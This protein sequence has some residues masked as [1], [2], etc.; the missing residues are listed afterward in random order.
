LRFLNTNICMPIAESFVP[1]PQSSSSTSFTDDDAD[2]WHAAAASPPFAIGAAVRAQFLRAC[3]RMRA[4]W[5][6]MQR[7]RWAAD[8]SLSASASASA[9]GTAS[10]NGSGSG[11]GSGAGHGSASEPITQP[12][13]RALF[14]ATLTDDAT[15]AGF[16]STSGSGSG[17]AVQ[18]RDADATARGDAAAWRD[19]RWAQPFGGP[20]ADHG[21]ISTSSSSS[22]THTATSVSTASAVAS[23]L[24]TA[25]V[26]SPSPAFTA[27]ESSS[28]PSSSAA[29]AAAALGAS[30]IVEMTAR[31]RVR[32][33][34]ASPMLV[35][36]V[37]VGR[38]DPCSGREA[39][40]CHQANVPLDAVHAAMRVGRMCAH[41]SFPG[42]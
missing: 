32:P 8:A 21:S 15:F 18:S 23:T 14:A 40:V 38:R 42:V 36:F 11:T 22:S 20:F 19:R 33:L 24:S 17:S 12:I 5:A 2:A 37:V 34:Y 27:H 10:G 13:P 1:S 41:A 3:V 35:D 7:R 9:S 39:F 31:L 30:A 26:S 28:S 16:G 4:R 29:A 6:V 25:P